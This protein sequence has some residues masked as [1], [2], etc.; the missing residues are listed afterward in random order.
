MT[1]FPFSLLESTQWKDYELLDSGDGL[2]PSLEGYRAMAALVP[3]ELL[4]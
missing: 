3:L 2:H 4:R 1:S